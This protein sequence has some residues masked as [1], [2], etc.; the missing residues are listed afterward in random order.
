MM[1]GYPKTKYY[2]LPERK[3]TQDHLEVIDGEQ[4]HSQNQKKDNK[5]KNLQERALDDVIR[6]GILFYGERS[7]LYKNNGRSGGRGDQD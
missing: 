7:L 2:R 3:N 6:T 4:K 1:V 5:T